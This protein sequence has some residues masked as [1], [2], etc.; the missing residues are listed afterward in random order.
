MNKR[1]LTSRISQ[2]EQQVRWATTSYGS[3]RLLLAL[4]GGADSVALL[5]ALLRCGRNVT[6]SHCNFH[7]RGEESNR[8]QRFVEELCD[9]LNVPLLVKHFDVNA[10][11]ST[12][13]GSMEM[14]CRDL[15]Y[16]WFHQVAGAEHC[17]R[18]LTAHH[19]DD[20]VETMLLHMMRSCGLE[21][22]KGMSIDNGVICR[23]LLTVSRKEI[24]E[25]LTALNQSY[26]TDSSNLTADPDRNFLRLKVL[27][28]LRERWP[29]AS[30]ALARVQNHL[31]ES[32][33]I[34]RSQIDSW[35]RTGPADRLPLS[36]LRQVKGGQTLLHEFLTANS[37][38]VSRE[39]EQE[40][41]NATL[42]D[43]RI[44]QKWIAEADHTHEVWIVREAECLHIVDTQKAD[45][46]IACEPQLLTP[47]LMRE[48]RAN[49]CQSRAWF[50]QGPESY[51]I[52]RWRAGDYICPGGMRGRRKVADLLKE[53]GIPAPLRDRFLLL[54]RPEPS[55]EAL[56]LP[57]LRRSRM[58]LIHE[59]ATSCFLYTVPIPE[60]TAQ[61]P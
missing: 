32:A 22:M 60:N 27:P 10:Y 55:S 41:F 29:H 35:L 2:L 24:T 43:I 7:L 51:C 21:A 4:S 61:L 18:I 13:G 1:H 39:M 30:D 56:W 48:I 47:D 25:Y 33:L 8:D 50:P 53:G 19:R 11:R 38:K 14:A 42:T 52:R 17:V 23:P 36:L 15:R 57:G 3:A 26:I 44:G 46:G 49:T 58:E 40:M 12:H 5:R 31:A 59:G 45:S 9:S 34:Y 6:A 54:A 16:E 37:L 28:L 20:N